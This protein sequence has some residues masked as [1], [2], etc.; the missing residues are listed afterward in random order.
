VKETRED[1]DRLLRLVGR[2]K[3]LEEEEQQMSDEQVR[4]SEDEVEAH[5]FDSVEDTVEDTVEAHDDGPDVEGHG[6]RMDT[7]EDTVEDVVE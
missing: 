5:A 6:F 4:T 1:F 3:S 7:V 2:C